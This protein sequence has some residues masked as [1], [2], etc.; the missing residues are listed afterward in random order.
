MEALKKRDRQP[1]RRLAKSKAESSEISDEKPVTTKGR[2]GKTQAKND[3]QIIEDQ[4][5]MKVL[6]CLHQKYQEVVKSE[7]CLEVSRWIPWIPNNLL[8]S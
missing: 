1:T 7:I 4:Q 3:K 6:Q 5:P 2:R 8:Q